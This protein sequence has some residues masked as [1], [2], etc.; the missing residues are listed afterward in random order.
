MLIRRTYFGGSKMMRTRRKTLEKSLKNVYW[1]VES[2][3]LLRFLWFTGTGW[4]T[5]TCDSSATRDCFSSYSCDESLRS[6]ICACGRQRVNNSFV[7]SRGYL[8]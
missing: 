1:E 2:Q 8:C 3:P 6:S 4:L 7:A 5:K